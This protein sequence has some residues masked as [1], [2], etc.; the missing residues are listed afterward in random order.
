MTRGIRPLVTAVW[1][2]VAL[3]MFAPH[4]SAQY[5]GQNKVQYDEFAFEVLTTEQFDIH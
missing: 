1:V 5:F 2:A 4:S 3:V